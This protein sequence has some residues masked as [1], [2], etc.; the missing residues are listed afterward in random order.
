MKLL[1][2]R[3]SE[4]WYGRAAFWRTRLRSSHGPLAGDRGRSACL[5]RRRRLLRLAREGGGPAAQPLGLVEQLPGV[6]LADRLHRV[7]EAAHVLDVE[8]P[9]V[10]HEE[11][12]REVL[13][14]RGG[15]R[16][17]DVQ[18]PVAVGDQGDVV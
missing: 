4:R 6:R 14:D 11:V 16:L 2:P 12:Q 15:H 9:K 17:A 7:V 5:R 13:P 8:R 3:S 18:R 10:F 1:Y